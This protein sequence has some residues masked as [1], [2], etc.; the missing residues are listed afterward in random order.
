[1]PKLVNYPERQ[2]AIAEA[3]WRLVLRHGVGGVSVRAVAAEADL[4]TAS[5]RQAFPTQDAL[6]GFCF[7]LVLE[8]AAAR[9]TALP[10]GGDARERAER[11][12][13]E[14]LPLDA[15]RAAEMQVWLSFAGASMTD[16]L[17]SSIYARGHDALR[18]LCLAVIQALAPE[19]DAQIEAGR[20]HALIDGLAMHLVSRRDPTAIEAAPR[21]LGT[22]LDSLG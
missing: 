15:E 13:L 20:L 6:L 12:L 11:T 18:E 5:L 1:M 17:L 9:I 3:A 2:V 21:I 4:A 8:R 14:V 7:E 19:V 16:P 22:H 10:A